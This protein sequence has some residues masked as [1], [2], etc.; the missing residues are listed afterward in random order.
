MIFIY[1]GSGS[2]RFII[3][4]FAPSKKRKNYEAVYGSSGTEPD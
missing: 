4:S 2:Y 1:F 3:G